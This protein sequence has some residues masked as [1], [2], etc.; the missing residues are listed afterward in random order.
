MGTRGKAWVG[1][2]KD[3]Q[4]SASYVPLVSAV[5]PS[6][7]GEDRHLEN[8][9]AMRGPGLPG[10]PWVPGSARCP[11][12]STGLR[13]ELWELRQGVM[14]GV[15]ESAGRECPRR[16]RRASARMPM[17]RNQNRLRALTGC[18]DDWRTPWMVLTAT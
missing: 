12:A 10:P 4:R 7:K 3:K 16:R 15:R 14:V 2:D 18:V 11:D 13:T 8:Q 1:E 17:R 6:R 5:E 9:D